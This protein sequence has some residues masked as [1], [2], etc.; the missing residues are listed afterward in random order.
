MNCQTKK[1]MILWR[2]DPGPEYFLGPKITQSNLK[3][4]V[5]VRFGGNLPPIGN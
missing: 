4:K 3:A 5:Q 1:V 2:F